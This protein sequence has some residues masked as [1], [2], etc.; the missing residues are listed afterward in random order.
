LSDEEDIDVDY[1][2]DG[3]E[4]QDEDDFFDGAEGLEDIALG[5]NEDGEE[6]GDGSDYGE[7]YDQEIE[8][9]KEATVLKKDKSGKK[10]K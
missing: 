1:S 10:N 3:E 5:G 2:D 9:E 4:P 7:E 8:E 6:M